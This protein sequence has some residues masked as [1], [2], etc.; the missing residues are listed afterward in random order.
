MFLRFSVWLAGSCNTQPG[1]RSLIGW[2]L[3]LVISPLCWAGSSGQPWGGGERGGQS[4][5]HFP[6]YLRNEWGLPDNS[7]SCGMS[8]FST[9]FP[10]Y[11][12][13]NWHAPFVSDNVSF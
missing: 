11:L 8:L 4:L 9:N 10:F 12:H 6:G 1:E 3:V 2:F 5:S 7:E 13:T